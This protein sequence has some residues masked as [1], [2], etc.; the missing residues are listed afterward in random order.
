MIDWVGRHLVFDNQLSSL[1]GH[2][3]DSVSSP[4][5][6]IDCAYIQNEHVYHILNILYTYLYILSG[7]D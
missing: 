3:V 6:V 2:L 4:F 1:H 5:A 7:Y